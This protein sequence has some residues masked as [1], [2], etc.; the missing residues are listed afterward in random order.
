MRSGSRQL[1]RSRRESSP[2]MKTSSVAWS[3]RFNASSVSR[4]K[5]LPARSRSTGL[6]AN[7]ERPAIERGNVFDYHVHSEYSVDCTVPMRASCEAAVT[8][9]VTE[10]AFTDHMDSQ[11]TDEGFGYYRID[12][13]LASVEAVQSDFSD[14]LVVL[15]GV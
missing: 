7:S 6:I 15:K 14:R 4:V 9:G 11:P 1:C 5:D 10:I 2:A 12:D 13:Y 8:A 3:C